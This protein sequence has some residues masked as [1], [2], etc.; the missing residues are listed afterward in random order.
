MDRSQDRQSGQ[1]IDPAPT[2]QQDAP[3]TALQACGFVLAAMVNNDRDWR[4]APVAR[5]LAQAIETLG[6]LPR[7][8]RQRRL[9]RAS[10]TLAGPPPAR[11][12]PGGWSPADLRPGYQCPPPL[13]RWLG[14][15]ANDSHDRSAD[16]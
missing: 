13:R 4:Q 15:L 8:E 7:A 11:G 14:Q 6:A 2:G 9:Q 5:G 16:A 10:A 3:R 1:V 12:T